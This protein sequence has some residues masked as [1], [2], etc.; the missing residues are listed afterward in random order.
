MCENVC[1]H[2]N[3]TCICSAHFANLRIFKIALRII[4]MVN[5]LAQYGNTCAICNIAQACLRNFNIAQ[6]EALAVGSKLTW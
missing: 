2:L 3:F 1:I 5:L 4:E 6:Q